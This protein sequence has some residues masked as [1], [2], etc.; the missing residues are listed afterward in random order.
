MKKFRFELLKKFSFSHLFLLRKK[1][2]YVLNTSGLIMALNPDSLE[3]QEEIKKYE[4]NSKNV[5]RAM[6]LSIRKVKEKTFT[7]TIGIVTQTLN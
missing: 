3:L 4:T 6:Q 1:M 2:D 7:S 5:D